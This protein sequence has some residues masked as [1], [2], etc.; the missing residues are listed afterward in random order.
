MENSEQDKNV[1]ES[2]SV[3]EPTVAWKPSKSRK[4][5]FLVAIITVAIFASIS[6]FFI[7]NI[8][9]HQANNGITPLI[10]RHQQANNTAEPRNALHA[11]PNAIYYSA[12]DTA[13]NSI[14]PIQA[15]SFLANLSV[16]NEVPSGLS[17]NIST[18]NMSEYSRSY[19]QTP[20]QNNSAI[21]R[22]FNST[23]PIII[24]ITIYVGNNDTWWS[25]PSLGLGQCAVDTGHLINESSSHAS[26]SVYWNNT[27]YIHILTELKGMQISELLVNETYYQRGNSSLSLYITNM[28]YK[29]VLMRIDIWRITSPYDEEGVI[30]ESA[31]IFAFLRSKYP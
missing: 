24:N 12:T 22:T 30:S 8:S 5:L 20:S 11:P 4:R 27:V 17:H 23:L 19:F 26:T 6:G 14:T 31:N 10:I 29:N 18:C 13:N 15:E 28:P 3:A 16:F 9:S 7:I 25:E 21:L 2:V 1:A